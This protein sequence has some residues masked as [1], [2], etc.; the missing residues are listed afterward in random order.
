MIRQHSA[1]ERVYQTGC[2]KGAISPWLS[3]RIRRLLDL[4]LALI[5]IILSAPLQILVALA[6]L[7]LDGWPVLFFHQRIGKMG[8]P[9]TVV[10]FRTMVVD[11]ESILSQLLRDK[12]KLYWWESHR[13]LTDDPRITKLGSKL[14]RLSIDELPQLWQVLAGTMSL[15]GPRPMTADEMA[16]LGL[17]SSHT[18]FQIRPG[19]SGLSQTSGRHGIP[20]EERLAVEES[21]IVACSCWLDLKIL[22]RTIREVVSRNGC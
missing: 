9:I 21:Y 4:A 18:I 1:T 17:D 22:I 16:Q 19:L 2:K 3:S 13:K 10:K 5:L 6:I 12:E 15:I 11:A 8:L 7:C 20:I 14:R